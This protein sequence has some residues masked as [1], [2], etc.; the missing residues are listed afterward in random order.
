MWSRVAAALFA[1]SASAAQAC[2]DPTNCPADASVPVAAVT[3]FQ[4]GNYVLAATLAETANTAAALAFAARA[5]I[6]D[7]VTRTEPCLDCLIK[8]E[9]TAE[10]A[11]RAGAANERALVQAYVQLAIAIGFH[12]RL[13]GALEAQSEA[14]AEKGRAAI[15][16]A[17]ELDPANPW[18]LA[19]LGGWHL[20]IVD[21]A[22]SLLAA[23]LY[24]ASEE[25]GLKNFR[26]ALTADPENLLLH[27][28][29]ALSILALDVE[30]FRDEAL[31]ALD[32]GRKDTRAD[33][34]TAF[35]RKRN[36]TL[37]A[38]I[39]QGDDSKIEGVVR[40]FQGYRRKTR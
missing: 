39:R 12:G 37:I 25:E 13:L 35:T 3:A 32:A 9:A 4:D 40:F 21:R 5:Q 10:A 28:H 27:H 14:L 16:K 15:D 20:E 1:L 33:A 23:A 8:A 36:D 34:M 22:G 17:L 11:I 19:S 2:P 6:A 31:A 30:R 7:A 18:T 24:D 38:V 29:Y 26:A